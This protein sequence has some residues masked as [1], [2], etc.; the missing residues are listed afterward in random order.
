VLLK[1]LCASER[2]ICLIAC[3]HSSS[4]WSNSRGF[5][6]GSG[7]GIGLA[8]SGSWSGGPSVHTLIALAMWHEALSCWGK[9]K[10]I[11]RVRE[12]CKSRRKQV[13]VQDNLACG[14]IPASFTKTIP[15]L[16][17]HPQIST[18]CLIKCILQMIFKV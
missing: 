2:L 12:H 1:F 6:W 13:F 16:Q 18:F 7:L 14:L 15:A 8:M 17:E 5:Q 3:D 11:F 10:T 9:K 4:S